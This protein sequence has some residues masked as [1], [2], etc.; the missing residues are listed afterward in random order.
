MVVFWLR[1]SERLAVA[2]ERRF[3]QGLASSRPAPPTTWPRG[4]TEAE[5]QEPPP[6]TGRGSAAAGPSTHP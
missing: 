5:L 4:S 6:A 3:D 2:D 1:E